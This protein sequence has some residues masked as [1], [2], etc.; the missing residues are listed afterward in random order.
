MNEGIF[1]TAAKPEL[2]SNAGKFMSENPSVNPNPPGTPPAGAAPASAPP[3]PDAASAPKENGKSRARL[4]SPLVVVS[5]TLVLAMLWF[6]GL[7]YFLVAMTHEST[8]D[9]FIAGHVVSIAPRIAGQVVAVHVLDNQ[10]VHSNDL[11]VEI[12][13]ADFATALAQ[14]KAAQDSENSSYKAAIAGYELMGVKV[15]TAE[16]NAESSKA[17]VASA[18]ATEV[19][20][21][22]DFERAQSLRKDQ[23]I[24][25][26]EFDQSKAT[27]DKAEADLNSAR[28]K[29]ASD[30]SKVNEANAQKDA[31]WA[32][33]GAVLAQFKQAGTEVDT[34]N[35]NLSYTKI[36]APGDGRVT[37]KQVE[38]GDYLQAGQQIMSLVPSDVWVIANFKESQ[39]EK[40]QTNQPV[41]VEIDALGGRKFRA[42]LDSVQAGSGA[43]FSLLP[44]ENA[45]GNFV[46]VVQRVP[47]KIVFDEALPADHTIG[48]GLSV[49]PSVQISSFSAPP[50]VTALAALVLAIV[51]V[52]LLRLILNRK[53]GDR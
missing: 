18:E 42:H 49:T 31:V 50:V 36:F 21:S 22:A 16:A 19:Q 11:L 14:K 5:V 12:D 39:L 27:I 45:T 32:E 48:P 1:N 10:L 35:L 40:M 46:K 28:Q 26:Q 8:D 37:R 30:D 3:P 53:N 17:D 7:S 43:Q 23:T 44:P 15:K 6:F 4:N 38:V 20:A 33:A 41:I 24:S 29:A 13:P 51:V 34:A 25:A 2:I 9:A 52:F 47:V